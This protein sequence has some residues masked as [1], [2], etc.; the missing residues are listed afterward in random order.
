MDNKRHDLQKRLLAYSAAA[1]VATAGATIAAP[2]MALESDGNYDNDFDIV[3]ESRSLAALAP[4]SSNSDCA[5]V[6]GNS[7]RVFIS[8]LP[9]YAGASVSSFSAA[10]GTFVVFGGSSMGP[11]V[12]STFSF[13]GHQSGEIYSYTVDLGGTSI[14]FLRVEFNKVTSEF[15]IYGFQVPT[16]IG[17]VEGQA[18]QAKAPAGLGALAAAALAALAT[19]TLWLRRRSKSAVSLE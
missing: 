11:V 17:G 3:L 6:I 19:A 5:P 8:S 13:T 14:P 7:A 15:C 4:A 18:S 9:Y 1:M 10:S 16:A 12:T 2:G